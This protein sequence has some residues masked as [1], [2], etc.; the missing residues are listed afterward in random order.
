MEK[1]QFEMAKQLEE[2]IFQLN[3]L[4]KYMTD[5][6]KCK[7][8]KVTLQIEVFD[9]EVTDHF[10]PINADR[11]TRSASYWKEDADYVLDK[12]QERIDDVQVQF[13]KI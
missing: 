4:K 12:I 9:E 6:L 11:Q 1:E 3:L 7:P 2:R 5:F 10:S 13:K 8:F